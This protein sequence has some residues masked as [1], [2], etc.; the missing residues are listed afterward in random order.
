MSAR[1]RRI[2]WQVRT[3]VTA[4]ALSALVALSGQHTADRPDPTVQPQLTQDDRS[5][6]FIG[7]EDPLRC[8]DRSHDREIVVTAGLWQ[9]RGTEIDRQQ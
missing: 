8:E 6:Q 1:A 5:A 7:L 2:V 3:L 4:L 9:G